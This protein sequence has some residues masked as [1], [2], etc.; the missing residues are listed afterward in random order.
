[1]SNDVARFDRV[2]IFLHYIWIMPF[3]AAVI[4]YMIWRNVEVAALAGVLLIA[5]QAVFIQGQ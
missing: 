2:F 5:V 4:T 3:Q 1:M